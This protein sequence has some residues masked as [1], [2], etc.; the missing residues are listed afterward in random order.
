MPDKRTFRVLSALIVGMTAISAVLMVLDPGPVH[1]GLSIPLS[2]MESD[3]A[4]SIDQAL[5]ATRKPLSEDWQYIIIHD[6]RGQAGSVADLERFWD[7][8]YASEG[9]SP[10]GAGYH[11]VVNDAAGKSDGEI[12]VCQ[13]WQEQYPGG[14][15]DAEGDDHWNRIAIGVCVMGDADA[16]SFSGDQMA[17]LTA[18]VRELQRKFNIP[19]ERVIVQVGQT[20]DPAA[21]F[22]ESQFRRQLAD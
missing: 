9:L 12:E 2:A 4:L 7:Q 8:Y 15:I 3:D 22:P 20:A 18:L 17:S 19:R 1:N 13:R 11:F 16:R 10:R 5:F 6:S 21:Y 14:Y